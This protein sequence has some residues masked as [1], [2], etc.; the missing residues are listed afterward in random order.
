MKAFKVTLRR[1][2]AEAV[3]L[4]V[5]VDPSAT[6]GALAEAL[7]AR[8]RQAKPFSGPVTLAMSTPEGSRTLAEADAVERSGL[9]SGVTISVVPASDGYPVV[10]PNTRVAMLSILAGPDRDAAPVWLPSGTSTIGRD[11][12]CAIRLNDPQVSKVHARIN[13]TDVVEIVDNNSTNGTYIGGGPVNR[14][15]LRRDETAQLGDTVISV[16]MHETTASQPAGRSSGGAY[17]LGAFNRSPRLDPPYPGQAFESPEPPKRPTAQRFPLIALFAPL[18]VGALLFLF[19][20]SVLSLMFMALSPL[21]LVGNFAEQAIAGKRALRRST[22]EFRAALAT[23]NVSLHQA[24]DVERAHRR[25]EH[26]STIELVDAGNTRTP[27]LWTRRPEHDSFLQL[28]LGLGRLPSRNSVDLPTKSEAVPELWTE[29]LEV[30]AAHSYVD[31]VPVVAR[32][33]ETGALGIAGYDRGGVP[34]AW[35]VIAQ[36]VVLHS[37]AEL[38]LAAVTSSTTARDWAWLTWLPH[39]SSHP[40][41]PHTPLRGVHLTADGAT[42]TALVS[43]LDDLIASRSARSKEP[44]DGPTLPIVVLLVEDDADADRGRLVDI[45]ERGPACGV[46][47]IWVAS[48]VENLPA[49]CRTFVEANRETGTGPVGFVH[50]GDQVDPVVL[51]PLSL[52]AVETLARNLAPLVDAGARVNDDTGLPLSAAFLDLAESPLDRSV[53]EVIDRWRESGSLSLDTSRP[54]HRPEPSLRALVGVR[55]V[56]AAGQPEPMHLD[57]RRDGPHALVGGTTGAGKSELLQSWILGMATAISPQRVTFLFVDYKGGAAFGACKDLPHTVGLVTDLSL[58]QVHRALTSLRA[59]V[60]R[61]E[62][63]L[64]E[65][66]AKDLADLEQSRA[67]IAP[68]RLVIVV[69]EFAALRT[70]VP[71][72][73]DGVVDIAQ[74]GRSLG[75][76]LILATQR[77]AGIIT[78]SLRAN[79]NLRVALRMADESD[80][81]DVLGSPIAGGFDPDTPGRAAAKSGPGRLV[82]FQAAYAGG[83]SNGEPPKPVIVIETLAFGRGRIWTD[84][85]PPVRLPVAELGP[86]DVT[87]VVT[88]VQGASAAVGLAPPRVPWQPELPKVLE[89][90][91]LLE[92]VPKELAELSRRVDEEAEEIEADSGRDWAPLAFGRRDLPKLQITPPVVFYPDKDGNLVVYGTGGTGKSTLLRTV[93]LSA[94]LDE[95]KPCEVYGVEFGG[96]GLS[97]LEPLPQV[98]AIIRGE[99]TP[100]L[101]RLM[102]YLREVIDA[103]QTRFSDHRAGTITEYWERTGD[104]T[105]ARILLLIDGMGGFAELHQPGTNGIFEQL[106]SVATGG[107]PVGIHVL[108]SADRGNAVPGALTSSLQQRLIMR[109]A[110][111]NDYGMVGLRADSIPADAPPG[112]GLLGADE[113]QV[114]VYGGADQAAQH[115]AIAQLVRRC[116]GVRVAD[117][118]EVL[119]TDIRLSDIA[120]EA[121]GEPVFGLN[122]TLLPVTFRPRG[123]FVVAGPAESGRTTALRTLIR[124]MLRWREHTRLYY[125]GNQGETPIAATAGWIDRATGLAGIVALAAKMQ[126]QMP[127]PIA[128]EPVMIVVE[129]AEKIF[130]ADGSFEDQK[131]LTQLSSLLEAFVDAGHLVVVD[132]DAAVLSRPWLAFAR[133][134][135]TGVLLRPSH[136]HAGGFGVP[137]PRGMRQ[138]DFPQGRGLVY[139]QGI[140]TVVQVAAADE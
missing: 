39:T 81:V 18:I 98:G 79:T 13:V 66:R 118:I 55:G 1:I 131:A 14:A 57:L 56:D 92:R 130:T 9:R 136:E 106:L 16:S 62:R 4:L 6:V 72:F 138:T 107:R 59:E 11:A 108:V 84:P 22:V 25:R 27:L 128:G 26:P 85:V 83:W 21:M 99:D 69:D 68:P 32:M 104:L 74:R 76:H 116:D 3:D 127:T 123:T 89:L 49:V 23:L 88:T 140:P 80:S 95:T 58:R 82:T 113:I 52:T 17:V 34:V 8:D 29:L 63:I 38:V 117:P 31:R 137:W 132:V 10:A 45:A 70:E 48:T 40:V 67:D 42:S 47:V 129:S 78:D 28:R 121:D 91:V 133:N 43:E 73:V 75:L 15:R 53:V 103:R 87:R 110:G 41:S 93:A 51:E 112:R 125:L 115:D 24:G 60:T 19:T 135:Q 97:M 77:P 134:R 2:N 100:R 86:N 124:S 119:S 61:R 101:V 12:K 105:R 50:H 44:S 114:A 37:P 71:E 36:L 5:S 46:H 30:V 65:Y 94:L 7:T 102:A 122:E 90:A 139:V 111:E 96:R 33:P 120:I 54:G 35:G 64:K 20:R 126:V 109:L